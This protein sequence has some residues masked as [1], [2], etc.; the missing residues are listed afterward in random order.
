MQIDHL[1]HLVLTVKDLAATCAFYTRVLG[2]E[3]LTFGEGRTALRF[4]DQKINL[5]VAGK[6]LPL[7]AEWATP[8]S[9]DLCFITVT[10]V[11]QVVAHLKDC[12]VEVIDGPGPRT[13]A[14]H[15]LESVYI[16][17]PDG[18]LIELSNETATPA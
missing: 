7:R 6:E 8:G 10:P 1:D 3:V 11:A 2:M 4:G 5:H 17:D 14:R 16:R 12:G 9:G 13:G 15:V 18:N